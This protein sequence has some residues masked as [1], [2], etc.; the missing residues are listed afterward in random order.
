M[1]K[2]KCKNCYQER[3]PKNLILKYSTVLCNGKDIGG[4][5]VTRK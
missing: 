1:L 4:D 2:K 5:K 3:N